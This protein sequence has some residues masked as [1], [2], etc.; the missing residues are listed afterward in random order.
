[1]TAHRSQALVHLSDAAEYAV[2]AQRAADHDLP[3][4]TRHD[5]AAARAA[6]NRAEAHL[7]LAE[8]TEMEVAS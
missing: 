2:H 3:T 4:T 8:A 7:D 1:M 6:L 5:I